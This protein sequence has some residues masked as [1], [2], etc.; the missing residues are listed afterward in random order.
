MGYNRTPRRSINALLEVSEKDTEK[1][2]GYFRAIK[3]FSVPISEKEE[4]S[5]MDAD[6]IRKNLFERFEEHFG[7]CSQAEIREWDAEIMDMQKSLKKGYSDVLKGLRDASYFRDRYLLKENWAI[8]EAKHTSLPRKIKGEDPDKIFGKI[9]AMVE[10]A[11]SG[12]MGPDEVLT[13]GRI[14]EK[15]GPSILTELLHKYFISGYPIKNKRSSWGLM[16]SMDMTG[17]PEDV[18]SHM[19]Y[20]QFISYCDEVYA[21][22]KKWC[23][24]KKLKLNDRFK[25]YYLDRY[26]QCEY[27]TPRCQELLKFYYND[28]EYYY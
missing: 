4:E 1:L 22:F 13:E 19:P 8:S 28:R 2:K 26:Y 3:A 20:S 6:E 14:L 7:D 9:K 10:A 27:E 21:H 15:L 16:L 18:L 12:K 11:E 17:V 25:Y 24:G 5:G 23:T